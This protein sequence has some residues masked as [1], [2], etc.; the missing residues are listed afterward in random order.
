MRWIFKLR[1][2]QLVCVV[3]LMLMFSEQCGGQKFVNEFL[4]IGV[5]ARAHGL[6]GSVVAST[7]DGASGYWNP[8]GLAHLESPLQLSVMHANWF[9]GIA[10][11]D[12]FSI[13]RKSNGEKGLG[14]S[15][16][17]I[18]LGVDNIPN[19][20]NLIGPDGSVNYD[21]VT[22]F[23]ASDVA[24]LISLGRKLSGDKLSLG[25]SIKVIHRSVGPFG[26]AWG[27]G[28]DVGLK[29][30]V[31]PSLQF[32]LLARD[33]TTT[34]TAWSFQFTE[35]EKRV[36]ASTGNVVPVS[37]TEIALPRLIAG[38]AWKG[39]KKQVSWLAE[40]NVNLSTD[41][42]KSGVLSANRIFFSPSLGLEAGFYRRLHVRAGMG[43]IQSVLQP[44]VSRT[45]RWEFQPTVGL[46]L[47]LGR[48]R[49]DYALAN[50]G[51][52]SGVLISH[53]FSAA[54]DFYP[55]K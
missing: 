22:N 24:G 25:G 6:S 23:S 7:T 43:N 47:R 39:E 4:Q 49:V 45:S 44:S 50:V 41:G 55:K 32:G 1:L 18:R 19:T 27:F 28:A 2:N 5:G 29:Y 37:S 3:F 42:T 21:R 31:S 46:G 53:I 33:V 52:V 13:A 17:L 11:Y 48:L 9:G 20:L 26:K 30:A 8:A 51:S 10:N 12:Y 54:L 38:L 35:E 34:F 40:I 15:F 16:T 36:F 14:V